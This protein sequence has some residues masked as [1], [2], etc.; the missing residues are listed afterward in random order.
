MM[1]ALLLF[2]CFSIGALAQAIE[3]INPPGLSKS[4]AYSHAVT[5]K[6]GRIV[7]IAGQVAQNAKGEIV[8]KG[9]FKA[10]LEQVWK[11]LAT[12]LAAAGAKFDD[13]VKINTYVVNY[14]ASMRDDVR[15]ARLKFMGPG[16]PP[17][18]TLVGVQ[19]L[20]TDDYLVEIE[21]TAVV[22]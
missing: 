16:E 19:A 20:A 10:Q 15:A 6:G 22:K 17:A 1:N 21:M 12:A 5:A 7:W 3:R 18:A 14:K 2:L 4:P 13:V 9:D 11:N 8:G